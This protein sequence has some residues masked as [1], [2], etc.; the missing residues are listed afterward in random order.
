MRSMIVAVAL[1]AAACGSSS[2]APSLDGTWVYSDSAG[3]AGAAATFNS[4]GNYV[5]SVLQITSSTTANAAIEKGTFTVSG[6]TITLTPQESSCTGADPVYTMSYSFQGSNLE[7]VESSGIIVFQ[8]DTST[9]S[10]IAIT[11]GCF[12][13]SGAFTA[14]PLAPVS[15]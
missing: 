13:S 1:L 10:D 15:N 5:L 2:K 9:A 3:T 12:S 4:N 6:S 14:S 8:P 7:L 11:D